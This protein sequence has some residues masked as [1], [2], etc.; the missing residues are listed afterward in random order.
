[1]L[2]K[3][4]YTSLLTQ[5][6]KNNIPKKEYHS[7]DIVVDHETN[8]FLY[9]FG[10]GWYTAFSES[11]FG[12]I[13]EVGEIDAPST[14]GE[15]VF[16]WSYQKPI[17]VIAKSEW[18]AYLLDE[19]NIEKM[20]NSYPDFRENLMR[21]CLA[22]ANER[23]REANIERTLDYTL[24]DTIESDT[25]R[26]IPKMLK[27]LQDTFSLPEV[28][29]IE[30]HEILENVYSLR[31]RSTL[32]IVPVNERIDMEHYE[33]ESYFHE[34]DFLGTKHA[35]IFR[36]TSRE[37]NYGFLVYASESPRIAGYIKRITADIIPN[38]IRIIEEN[39]K[40]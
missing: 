38:C 35:H 25:T 24:I 5:C 12:T 31:Y 37:N 10:D 16:F 23:I 14:L 8:H 26:S 13:H 17:K 1:M 15:G 36:L 18:Y 2:K 33:Q 29:W 6:A 34:T 21:A 40:K 32:G 27:I 20:T 3:S 9:L 22:T 39:W 19:K 7:G 30:R 4:L 11:P 28:L